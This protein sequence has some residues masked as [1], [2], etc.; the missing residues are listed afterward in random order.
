MFHTNF[1]ENIKSYKK[2]MRNVNKCPK[3]INLETIL[4]NFL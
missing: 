4:R 3:S 2:I 1:I